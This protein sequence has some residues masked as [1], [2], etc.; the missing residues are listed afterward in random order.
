MNGYLFFDHHAEFPKGHPEWVIH[1]NKLPAELQY[2]EKFQP[3]AAVATAW[4]TLMQVAK[5]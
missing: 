3:R 1:H 4:K 5:K 2:S